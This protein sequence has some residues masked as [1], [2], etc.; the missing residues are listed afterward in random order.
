MIKRWMRLTSDTKDSADSM[1]SQVDSFMKFLKIDF[2]SEKLEGEF[3][4]T[5]TYE[6]T[7]SE[8]VYQED[9]YCGK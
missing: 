9:K 1:H 2:G 7:S 3:K 5:L 6:P 8:K 4:F